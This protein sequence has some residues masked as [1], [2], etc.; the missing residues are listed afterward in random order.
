MAE[1]WAELESD[2]DLIA[3]EAFEVVD[4]MALIK[5]VADG[6]EDVSL[7]TVNE[8]VIKTMVRQGGRREM[9]EEGE[10]DHEYLDFSPFCFACGEHY[11]GD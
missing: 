10:C 4:K 7:L 1:A 5:A 8:S 3:E 2:F 11:R 6:R 9:P